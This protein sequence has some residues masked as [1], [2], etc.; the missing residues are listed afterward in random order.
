[1]RD[2][3][4]GL[5]QGESG[6]MMAMMKVMMMMMMGSLKVVIVCEEFD[7]LSG[8]SLILLREWPCSYQVAGLRQSH[9]F[10]A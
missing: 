7:H 8:N 9:D 6:F 1:M 4:G 5:Y 3:Y 10:F 2:L